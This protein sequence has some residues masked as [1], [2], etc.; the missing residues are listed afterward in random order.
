MA[1]LAITAHALSVE[2]FGVVAVLTLLSVFLGFGDLGLGSLLNTRLPSSYAQGDIEESNALVRTTAAT[3][4]ATGTVIAAVGSLSIVFLPW[5]DMLGV[6]HLSGLQTDAAV[7]VFFVSGGLAL[8]ATLG[9]RVMAA[10]LRT[11]EARLWLAGGAVAAVVATA[12]CAAVSAPPWAYVLATSGVLTS[13]A[14][15][16][17]HWVFVRWFPELRPPAWRANL[18]E[19]RRNL[20]AAVPF[21][22]LTSSS[23]VAYAI[24]SLVVSSILDA[25]VAGVYATTARLF[26][27]IGTTVLLAGQQMWSALADAVTRGDVHWVRTRFRH[28]IGITA[29]ITF[30]TS[31]ILVV[32]GRPIIHLW[33]GQARVPPLSL[34]L[35]FFVYTVLA[36]VVQQVSYLLLALEQVNVL[37]LVGVLTAV[38][39]LGSSI[40]LTHLIGIN[41][42]V[43][44]SVLGLVVVMAVPLWVLTR[45]ALASL[46]TD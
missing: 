13:A 37:A 32:L 20:R 1:T 46:S 18:I 8:P 11:A 45:R 17:S 33:A 31:A 21:A 10:M 34:L 9:S 30:L 16:Q 36:A 22:L 3:L 28:A 6:R 14:V 25:R 29:G 35:S 23:L 5:R 26:A 42:P 43:L 12:L 15:M 41:G 39:N 27:I 40:L 4:L 19:V 24:D 7:L 38:V 2:S 44:G